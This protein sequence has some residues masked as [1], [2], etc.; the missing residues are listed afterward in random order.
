MEWVDLGSCRALWHEGGHRTAVVLP[1]ASGGAFQTPV[2]YLSLALHDAG[3]GVLAVDDEFDGEDRTIANAEAA[4]AAREPALLA[5][6]SRGTRAAELR[7]ELPAIWLTPLLDDPGVAAALQVR[8]GPQLLVGGTN[9]PT[10]LP[11]IAR[12]IPGEVLEVEGADHGF[13]ADG[14]AVASLDLLKR[15]IDG[16]RTFARSV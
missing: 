15:A 12:R 8:T 10:W 11:E 3:F 6:K 2:F 13:R 1:G 9:D 4:F 14:D 16:S 5:G 7:P